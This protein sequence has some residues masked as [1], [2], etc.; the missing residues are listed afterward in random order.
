[1]ITFLRVA[2]GLAVLTLGRQLY[3]LFVAGVG[4]FLGMTLAT[5]ILDAPS[6]GMTLLIALVAGLAGGL[7][8]LFL[9]RLAIG[10][11]GFVGGGVI[12]INLLE[13]LEV[14]IGP[15]FV[16]FLIGGLV[17]AILVAVLFDWALILLS[18]FA[19]AAFIVQTFSFGRPVALVMLFALLVAGIAIQANQY[20]RQ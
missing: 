3:W 15:D 18:S 20:Q 14:N 7:L 6:A 4:F 11:A 12:A 19:G 10:I 2:V 8:A 9:Q 16:P 1:M 17:G 5:R 13:L